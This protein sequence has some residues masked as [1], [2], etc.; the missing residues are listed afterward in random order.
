MG[1]RWKHSVGNRLAGKWIPNR[2]YNTWSH[3]VARCTNPKNADY[4][5]YGARGITV[6]E[7]WL[8]YDNFYE[9][10]LVSGYADNLTL[11]RED[12]SKGYS[13]DNCRW[14][15]M[16]TQSRNRRGN[17]IVNGK[18]LTDIGKETG[19]GIGTLSYRYRKDPSISYEE[20]TK[21]VNRR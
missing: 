2:I 17:V 6:C 21:P 9:W 18:Y 19:I 7:E 11:D 10:A 12:N 8:S 13:P 14:V 16:K 4:K 5:D 3:M 20:L 1:K 15:T